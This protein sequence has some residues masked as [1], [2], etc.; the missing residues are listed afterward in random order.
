MKV[1][2][3]Q[4]V[5]PVGARVYVDGR[6]EAI[7]AQSF[8]DGSTS[9][10]GPHYCVRFVGGGPEQVK[11]AMVRVGVDAARRDLLGESRRSRTITWHCRHRN[12]RRWH[13]PVRS[14]ERPRCE[15]CGWLLHPRDGR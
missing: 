11:V 10:W 6:D 8:P 5:F 14:T 15:G 3:P 1:S 13:N 4:H 12:C 9:L 2:S 7:V